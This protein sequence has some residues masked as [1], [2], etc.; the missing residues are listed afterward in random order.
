MHAIFDEIIRVEELPLEE[1]EMYDIGM[2][3][4]PHT[5]FANDILVHN[6]LFLPALPMIENPDEKTEDELIQE[7]LKVASEVQAVINRY[8]DRYGQ[9][10]HNV[11]THK[12]NI[13]QEMV[14]R[15]AFWGSAKKR[16]AMWIINKNGLPFDEAEIKGFDVVRSSFPQAFRVFMREIIDDILHDVSVEDLNLKIRNFK[17][18]YTKAP[19]QDILLPSGVKEISKFKY[20]QKATP[21][22]V[23]SAQNYNRFCELNKLESVA[24]MDD[25]DKILWGYVKQNPYNFDTFSIRGYDDPP[26]CVTFFEKYVDKETIFQNALMSKL[27]TIWDDLG[28]GRIELTENNADFF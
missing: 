13:K 22:H 27:E 12:W 3:D 1:C 16:Y 18:Q 14:G 11:D 21:I 25:G 19:I 4:T 7:T 6:S 28:W 8:Y 2:V 10:Y 24:K 5:F 15:R 20:G 26:E 17:H 9:R 23:K